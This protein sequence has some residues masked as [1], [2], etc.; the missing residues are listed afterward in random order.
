MTLSVS[1]TY[2]R[3]VHQAS[4]I[5]S[6]AQPNP[7]RLRVLI[8]ED[9][10]DAAATLEALLRDEGYETRCVFRGREVVGTARDFAADV[11]LLD[12]GMPGMDGYDIARVFRKLY[13]S[14]APTLIAVTAWQKSA[15]KL[16][17]K[18]AGFD[19]HVGK[20]YDPKALLDLLA[21]TAPPRG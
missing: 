2:N 20:P 19:H 21:E 13:A 14:A 5:R 12:I 9:D 10:R 3:G 15:D 16:M 8:A 1:I 4:S 11:V 18:H 6:G 7:R 17:A